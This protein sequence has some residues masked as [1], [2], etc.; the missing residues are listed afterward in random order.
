MAYF[1]LGHIISCHMILEQKELKV[2][3]EYTA[4]IFRVE[5]IRQARKSQKRR[6]VI[7]LRC[8]MKC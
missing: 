5:K 7:S 8:P 6:F 3:E 4:Y 2:P 1:I